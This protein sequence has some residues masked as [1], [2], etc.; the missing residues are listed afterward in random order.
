VEIQYDVQI[1]GRNSEVISL[2]MHLSCFNAWMLESES[3]QAFL[4]G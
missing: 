2:A 3:S 1:S 4:T